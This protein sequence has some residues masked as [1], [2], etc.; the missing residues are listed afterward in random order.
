M[1]WR[2]PHGPRSRAP[3][4]SAS[5]QDAYFFTGAT[6]SLRGGVGYAAFASAKFGL[7]AVAQSAAREL[8]PKNIHVAH[9]VI[10]SGVDTA[11]VR[12]RIKEHEGA[13]ALENLE[14]GRLMTAC[15]RSRRPTGSSISSLATRGHSNRKFVPSEKNGDPM[16]KVE[17]HFDF[18][19]PNAYLS[20]LVIPEIE[21]RTGIEFELRAGSAGWRLQADEQSLA[22]TKPRRNQKQT[23]ST[24]ASRRADSSNATGSR[25]SKPI[26]SSR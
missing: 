2:L 1:L 6:A 8:G 26:P 7:R 25:A 19:S 20:H 9:L 13:A 10:D 18:G 15:I 12:D 3:D 24:S 17:F 21:K 16:V 11:W 22:G 5:A 23:C 14:P 4:E